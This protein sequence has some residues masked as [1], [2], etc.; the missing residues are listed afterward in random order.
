MRPGMI[1]AAAA[2]TAGA[3][4]ATAIVV[5][6]APRADD[7]RRLVVGQYAPGEA[8]A[9]GN[10]TVAGGSY[11]VGYTAEVLFF[12]PDAAA[13]LSCALVDTSGQIGYVGDTVSEV[14]ANGAWTRI[15]ES[16]RVDIPSLS[17]GLRCASSSTAMIGVEF[18]DVIVTADAER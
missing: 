18:R 11:R 4:G 2:I 6:L 9:L 13:V 3:L 15:V 10:L 12:S 5:S 1:A 7:G 8:I 16:E 17:L 14:R